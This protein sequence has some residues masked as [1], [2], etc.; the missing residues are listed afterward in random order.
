MSSAPGHLIAQPGTRERGSHCIVTP[1]CRKTNLRMVLFFLKSPKQP[2]IWVQQS[3]PPVS[4]GLRTKLRSRC[5]KSMFVRFPQQ[6]MM[7]FKIYFSG[8]Q[9]SK[10]YKLNYLAIRCSGLKCQNHDVYRIR[11]NMVRRTLNDCLIQSWGPKTRSTVSK[12]VKPNVHSSCCYKPSITEISRLP[13]VIYPIAYLLL[14]NC[15]WCTATVLAVA[16]WRAGKFCSSWCLRQ[17]EK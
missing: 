16:V 3:V 1:E 15:L 10:C 14:T 12:P 8:T 17:V 13:L 11:Y 7:E 5:A 9:G 2:V 6:V 4:F